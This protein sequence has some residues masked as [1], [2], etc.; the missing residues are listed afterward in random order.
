MSPFYSGPL[1]GLK[2]SIFGE[3]AFEGCQEE[4]YCEVDVVSAVCICSKGNAV[5]APVLKED[6]EGRRVSETGTCPSTISGHFITASVSYPGYF[7]GPSY[8]IEANM[9]DAENEI[10]QLGCSGTLGTFGSEMVVCYV[11]GDLF[12]PVTGSMQ[13]AVLWKS[14]GRFLWNTRSK[15]MQVS[16]S[17]YMQKQPTLVSFTV[18]YDR[19]FN[20]YG[21][22]RA[23]HAICT[24]RK[25][26]GVRTHVSCKGKGY[27]NAGATPAVTIWMR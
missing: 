26:H 21:Y 5:M 8:N 11:R 14:N 24:E 20:E 16:I 18:A 7:P 13:V 4:D 27:T 12:S 2:R 17:K 3:G 22:S 9:L 6:R 10:S 25:V 19:T 15:R 23:R 1:S